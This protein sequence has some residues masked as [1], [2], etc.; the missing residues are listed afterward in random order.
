MYFRK[1]KHYS[2]KHDYWTNETLKQLISLSEYEE[3]A[4]SSDEVKFLI[5]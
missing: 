4:I 2:T 1:P 5:S 3:G